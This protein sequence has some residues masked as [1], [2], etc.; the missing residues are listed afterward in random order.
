MFLTES[1]SE[2]EKERERGRERGRE[3]GR[4]RA[5]LHKYIIPLDPEGSRVLL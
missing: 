3:K 1:E 4:D 2:R 5:F